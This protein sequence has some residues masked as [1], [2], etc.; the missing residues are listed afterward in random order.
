MGRWIKYQMCILVSELLARSSLNA[1]TPLQSQNSQNT[2]APG[3]TNE[4]TPTTTTNHNES[5]SK[6]G[7]SRDASVSVSLAEGLARTSAVPKSCRGARSL[8]GISLSIGWV[9]RNNI[10]EWVDSSPTDPFEGY[11]N[12]YNV[13]TCIAYISILNKNPTELP[14]TETL[15][16]D[17]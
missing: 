10:L 12:C 5:I 9:D 16:V 2:A 4:P 17:N 15:R 3:Q 13:C 1:V 7:S 8:P 11:P 14:D 6:F